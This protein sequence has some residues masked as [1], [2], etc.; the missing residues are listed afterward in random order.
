MIEHPFLCPYCNAEISVLLDESVQKASYVE[1]CEVC[2]N[3]MEI[4]YQ[5]EVEEVVLFE[6]RSIEQ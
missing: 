2:C 5:L 4:T 6:A 1:D 3:P